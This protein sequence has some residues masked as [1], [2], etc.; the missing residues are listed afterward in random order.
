MPFNGKHHDGGDVDWAYDDEPDFDYS[1]TEWLKDPPPRPEHSAPPTSTDPYV[2]LPSVV[3]EN[4][5]FIFALRHAP[6]VLYT[7]FKQYGQLGVLGWCS[8]FSELIDALKNL[9]FGGNMFVSTRQQ[10][11]QTCSDILKLKLDI[12]MQIIIMYLSSQVAR[13]RR[14]LDGETVFDDYPD[15]DFP[16]ES[17]VSN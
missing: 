2:P 9:G 7:R 14:F 17:L 5:R 11:L 1:N 3:E 10:A 6:N 4:E 16:I 13:M 12:K 8:E 15:T